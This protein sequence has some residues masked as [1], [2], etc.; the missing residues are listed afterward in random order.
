MLSNPHLK[1]SLERVTN[2]IRI[3]RSS[4]A[5][6]TEVQNMAAETSV[7]QEILR[8]ID[9]CVRVTGRGYDGDEPPD[10]A[11]DAAFNQ[12]IDSCKPLLSLFFH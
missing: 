12:I 9:L 8:F 4:L 1:D 6:S 7:D 11:T 2:I 3:A 10:D 5:S